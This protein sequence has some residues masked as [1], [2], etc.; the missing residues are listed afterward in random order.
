[1]HG[2]T[3]ARTARKPRLPHPPNGGGGIETAIKLFRN[4]K[5]CKNMQ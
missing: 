1:M 3:Q 4:E 2:R 5:G